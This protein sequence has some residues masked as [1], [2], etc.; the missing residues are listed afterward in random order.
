MKKIPF[1]S[2]IRETGKMQANSFIRSKKQPGSGSI[3]NTTPSPSMA[4]S[5]LPS[6]LDKYEHIINR[7]LDDLDDSSAPNSCRQL[8]Q[9]LQKVF[10]AG[11]V[12]YS[13]SGAMIQ[14]SRAANFPEAI[15]TEEINSRLISWQSYLNTHLTPCI[16]E[17]NLNGKTPAENKCLIFPLDKDAAICI[18]N[19]SESYHFLEDVFGIILQ[20][21]YHCTG[22][23]QQFVPSRMIRCAIYD[24]IKRLYKYVSDRMY[25]ERFKYFS[26][27]LQDIEMHFEPI[28]R[29]SKYAHSINIKSWEALARNKSTQRAPVNLFEAAEIWGVQFQT[30]LDLY[31]LRTA[32]ETYIPQTRR[33]NDVQPLAVNVYPATIMRDVYRRE[34]E[35]LMEDQLLSDDEKLVLEISEKT[36]IPSTEETTENDE[37]ADFRNV[38]V[39]LSKSFGIQFAIDDFGVGYASISRLNRL[40]PSYVKI[41]RDILHYEHDLGKDVIQY[42]MNLKHKHIVT[43]LKIIME[44]VDSESKIP[45]DVLVNELGIGYAQGHIF[46]ESKPQ[47][48]PRLSR[49][50]KQEISA[51]IAGTYT[52]Q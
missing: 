51:R 4:L 36:L 44:G 49:E 5:R 1:P 41:D 12:F 27:D 52:G 30:E 25:A 19:F 17:I 34:L 42:L 35:N 28:V 3:S 39:E 21:I 11:M 20:E 24:R 14:E 33:F 43:G 2:S 7:L 10:E 9:S 50:K 8:L 6:L 45:L 23:F 48:D 26:E 29:V 38:M 13:H 15:Q 32:L 40:R 37:F 47:I 18:F 22:Q 31:C 46:C 16:A